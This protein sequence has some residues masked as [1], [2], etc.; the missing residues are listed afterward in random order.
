MRTCMYRKPMRKHYKSRF[1]ALNLHRRHEAV[2]MDTIFSDVA[3]INSGG[4]K[5]VQ[6]FVG[7]L[8][9]VTDVYPMR[10]DGEFL[11]TL[12]ENIRKRG[13]MDKLLSNN[14]QA[15]ISKA[16][17]DV[18]HSLHI[19]N[20]TSKPHYQNQNP[21]ECRYNTLSTLRAEYLTILAPLRTHGCTLLC[22]L[23]HC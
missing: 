16:V 7:V 5:A 12:E 2:A 10:T 18:L 11:Q 4:C 20:W 15:E 8:S 22:T 21:A 13:A 17:M 14:A 6:I 19:D 9:L 3:G 23:V 1:P